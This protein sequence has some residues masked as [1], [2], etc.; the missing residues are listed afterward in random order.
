VSVRQNTPFEMG[1]D[2]LFVSSFRV[3]K[4]GLYT[5]TIFIGTDF[6]IESE[7][8]VSVIQ[9][10]AIS[11]ETFALLNITTI[12]TACPQQTSVTSGILNVLNLTVYKTT[13]KQAVL[14]QFQQVFQSVA[15]ATQ[16]YS[17]LM[18]SLTILSGLIEQISRKSLDISMQDLSMFSKAASNTFFASSSE[19]ISMQSETSSFLNSML[20][21]YLFEFTRRLVP[22]GQTPGSAIGTSFQLRA[23]RAL[24][25][26]FG[27]TVGGRR[28]SPSVQ[29]KYPDSI[30][31]GK[32]V[33]SD[34]NLVFFSLD[35]QPLSNRTAMSHVLSLRARG[36]VDP[37][38]CG[39]EQCIDPDSSFPDPADILF[40]KHHP[41][42]IVSTTESCMYW[43]DTAKSWSTQG[44][45]VHYVNGTHTQ[46]QCFHFSD[47]GIVMH[48]TYADYDHVPIFQDSKS[49]ALALRFKH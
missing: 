43:S 25:S 17:E 21:D 16:S 3:T 37:L 14:S 29:L 33:F 49:V 28:S 8:D 45:I 19:E 42:D 2:S 47:F 13:M 11:S 18:R 20:S 12:W 10:T 44:C 36:S 34:V 30:V 32:P 1:A 22:A 7:V 4:S 9:T 35:P 46:C 24:S 15:V 27:A 39:I 23:N 26:R 31:S 5:G 48:E 38:S 40:E 41:A 6:E